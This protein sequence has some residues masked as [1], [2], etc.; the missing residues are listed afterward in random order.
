MNVPDFDYHISQTYVNTTHASTNHE[1]SRRPQRSRTASMSHA[2][3][4]VA[5]IARI[6][7]RAPPS[8]VGNFMQ[9]RAFMPPKRATPRPPVLVNGG[10]KFV[11]VRDLTK[12]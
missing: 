5:P 12:D 10:Q 7:I 2:T 1:P 3:S 9:N 8:M 6:N 4:I 11:A